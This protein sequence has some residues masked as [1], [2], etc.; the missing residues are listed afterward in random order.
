MKKFIYILFLVIVSQKV[1]SQDIILKKDGSEINCEI[2]K[3]D[4][5][6]IQYKTEG[7][8]RGENQFIDRKDVLSYSILK[9]KK[10]SNSDSSS[11]NLSESNEF[12]ILIVRMNGGAS[13]PISS[14]G[15]STLV[16]RSS[17]NAGLGYNFKL[18]TAF[19]VTSFLGFDI[20]VNGINNKYV[21][22][23]SGGNNSL[24]VSNEKPYKNLF[25]GGGLFFTFPVIPS[26]KLSID[27]AFNFGIVK[28]RTPE[29]ESLNTNYSTQ[30]TV[31]NKYQSAP[32][33][34]MAGQASLGFRYKLNKNFAINL[35]CDYFLA[36]V[37]Y[38]NVF[39]T[40]RS[41]YQ[42]QVY[43]NTYLSSYPMEMKILNFNIGFTYSVF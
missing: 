39:I 21:W 26:K 36:D 17:G 16:E 18:S 15:R 22:P 28:A 40:Q 11:I 27:A 5:L 43:S 37:T 6:I 41:I 42:N 38:R 34:E 9:P 14:F 12:P 2:I 19:M 10:I 23:N 25:V 4:D 35:N 31:T 8:N 3:I 20:S 33:F 7:K 29:F 1:F 32:E 30:N 24:D 13:L